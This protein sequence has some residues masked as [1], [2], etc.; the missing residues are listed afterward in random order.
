M[1]HVF[2]GDPRDVSLALCTD[3]VNPFAHNR[4]VYSMWPI[5]LTLFNLPRRLWNLCT[6]I[7]LV[8][9]V[10][11]NEGKEKK[12][13]DPFLEVLVDKLL[14]IS[15]STLY[16]AYEGAPFQEKVSILLHVLDYPDIGKVMSVVGSGGIHGCAFCT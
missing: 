11:R 5:I 13:L 10:P 4:V 7:L 8:G 6:N 3:G 15:S 1:L 2:G 12:P 9:I 16:D 14:Q